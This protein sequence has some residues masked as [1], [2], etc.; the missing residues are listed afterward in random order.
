MRSNTVTDWKGSRS[1]LYCMLMAE[2]V[3]HIVIIFA[4]VP[5]A[6]IYECME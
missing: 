6:S 1:G 2:K 3:V 4:F 5:R